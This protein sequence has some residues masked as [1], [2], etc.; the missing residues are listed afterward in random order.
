MSLAFSKT[1]IEVNK[2]L[3]EDRIMLSL[4]SPEIYIKE[5]VLRWPKDGI[6]GMAEAGEGGDVPKKL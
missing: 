3:L 5:P 6:E 4:F 2:V 1:Y